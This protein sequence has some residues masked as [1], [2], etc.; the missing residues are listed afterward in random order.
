LDTHWNIKCSCVEPQSM[1]KD[2]ENS[3]NSSESS[4]NDNDENA[5]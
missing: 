3:D 4:E 2:I 1:C 5:S